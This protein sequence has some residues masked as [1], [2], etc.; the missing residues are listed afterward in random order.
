MIEAFFPEFQTPPDCEVL[1][2]LFSARNRFTHELIKLD[3]SEQEAEPEWS[4]AE[5]DDAFRVA[6]DFLM[7]MMKAIPG[8]LEAPIIPE[9]YAKR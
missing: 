9:K 1:D 6:G 4:L 3:E 2:K 8:D 7:A 5:V